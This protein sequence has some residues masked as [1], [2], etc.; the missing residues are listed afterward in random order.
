M[1]ITLFFPDSSSIN[2]PL[3][4]DCQLYEPEIKQYLAQ[5]VKDKDVEVQYQVMQAFNLGPWEITDDDG[6]IMLERKATS[7]P[8]PESLAPAPNNLMQ[9][10]E[11]LQQLQ[12]EAK[13][14][15]SYIATE[16][17]EIKNRVRLVEQKEQ[18][19]NAIHQQ[20][21]ELSKELIEL[22]K[23]LNELLAEESN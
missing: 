5:C 11:L 3:P 19:L 6:D 9:K 17:E 7:S 23:L 22:Q 12:S 15:V 2:V 8:A 10:V 1:F 4:D 20:Q 14:L 13:Q 21:R 18:E 16:H